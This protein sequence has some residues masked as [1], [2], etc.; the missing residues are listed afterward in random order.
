MKISFHEQIKQ[1]IEN[2]LDGS[3]FALSDFYDIAA[4]KTVSKSL[5][6]LSDSGTL[7]K[8][9]RGIFHKIQSDT[10]PDD[11]TRFPVSDPD[12][13]Q[14]AG[15]IA[16]NNLWRVIPSG[17][18]ALYSVGI[19][20]EKPSSWTYITDGIYRKYDL[21]GSVITFTHAASRFFS[22]MSDETAL[23]VQVLKAYGMNRVPDHL[24]EKLIPLFSHEQWLRIVDESQNTTAW[25]SK[26]IRNLFLDK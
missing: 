15:A 4:P 20:K 23:I 12:P 6:R 25:I 22:S 18:T 16:R 2:S 14:L 11:P 7:V 9:F 19:L 10:S 17:A 8:V 1:R 24:G 3:V 21:C 26:E 5:E 13:R